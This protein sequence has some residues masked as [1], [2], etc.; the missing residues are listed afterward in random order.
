MS[1]HSVC[2]WECIFSN[3]SSLP[4]LL[5]VGH[6]DINFIHKKTSELHPV[7]L[8][9]WLQFSSTCSTVAP[10]LQSSRAA[11]HRHTGINHDK[12]YWFHK[13]VFLRQQSRW[14]AACRAV[15]LPCVLYSLTSRQ[16]WHC[17]AWHNGM[18][19]CVL[20]H[21]QNSLY[22]ARGSSILNQDGYFCDQ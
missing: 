21:T 18:L 14:T 1:L 22:I 15:A 3:I 17:L 8:W 11:S 9:G 16:C 7:P 5:G 4:P 13:P 6:Q 20:N 19:M 12:S 2:F 10:L